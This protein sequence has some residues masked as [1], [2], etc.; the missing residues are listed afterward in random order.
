MKG[1]TVPVTVHILDKDYRIACAK[2]EQDALLAAARHLNEKM[3]EIRNSGKVVG[4]D[5]IAVMVALNL[6]HEL[7]GQQSQKE[8]SSQALS[9][10][11]RALQEKVE[12][13][14]NTSRQLEL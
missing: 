11:I 12:I 4:S 6:A 3:S 9:K 14:L 2:G 13:A 5:R 7:L 1:D 10:R 8:N